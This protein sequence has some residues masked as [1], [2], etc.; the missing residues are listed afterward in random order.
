[1]V[2][3]EMHDEMVMRR[4]GANG[5]NDYGTIPSESKINLIAIAKTQQLK[6]AA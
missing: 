6:Q 1:A 5:I 2:L 3:V 4:A